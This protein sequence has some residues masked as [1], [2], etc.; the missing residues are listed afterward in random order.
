MIHYLLQCVWGKKNTQTNNYAKFGKKGACENYIPIPICTT[1]DYKENHE[2]I[3][4]KFVINVLSN[5]VRHRPLPLS[6]IITL[7]LL[8]QL[9]VIPFFFTRYVTY[10]FG[11]SVD[12]IIIRGVVATKLNLFKFKSSFEFSINEMF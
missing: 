6:C 10:L 11:G 5:F 2:K 9:F 8:F 1:S 3:L 4:P 12:G 7:N